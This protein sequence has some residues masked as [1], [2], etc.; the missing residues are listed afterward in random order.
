M[1]EHDGADAFAVLFNAAENGVEFTV[2]GAPQQDWELALSTDPEQQVA[3]E[4]DTLIVRDRS[5]T[6][7]RSRA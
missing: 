5:V 7:L 6:V 2:P 1:L 4:S 3:A